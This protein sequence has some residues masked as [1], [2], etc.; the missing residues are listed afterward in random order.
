MVKVLL[1]GPVGTGSLRTLQT[2]VAKL[3]AS[4]NGP[5]D[6]LFCTDILAVDE[7]R[8][9]AAA[10]QAFSVP[11]F[12]LSSTSS[13]VSSVLDPFREGGASAAA[14]GATYLGACGVS[15]LSGL[16]VV[17][18]SLDALCDDSRALIKSL[19]EAPDALV[20][21]LMLSS[22]TPLGVLK[23]APD[24][25]ILPATAR[26]ALTGGSVVAAALARVAE[27]RY[28]VSGTANGAAYVRAPYINP[29]SSVVTRFLSLAPVPDNDAG[30][31]KGGTKHL[32]ALNLEPVNAAA[33]AAVVPGSTPSPY[34]GAAAAAAA[35]AAAVLLSA[36]APAGTGN[37]RSSGTSSVAPRST[38]GHIVGNFVPSSTGAQHP[39]ETAAAA[40]A[41]HSDGSFSVGGP[42]SKRPRMQDAPETAASSS[43]A[44]ASSSFPSQDAALHAATASSSTAPLLQCYSAPSSGLTADRIN[45]LESEARG[46]PGGQYFW[47]V[48]GGGPGGGTGRGGRGGRGG[49]YSSGR[50]GGGYGHANNGGG[51]GG[52]GPSGANMTQI[53]GRGGSG[54]ASDGA[55]PRWDN[56]R[57]SHQQQQRQQQPQRAPPECWF[58]LASPHVEKHLVVAIGN[59]CYLGEWRCRTA[60]AQR[61]CIFRILCSLF[62]SVYYSRNALGTR[63][64]SS[65]WRRHHSYCIMRLRCLPTLLLQRFLKAASP[66]ITSWWCP[67]STATHSQ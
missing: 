6:V 7:L 19:A 15:T 48:R 1:A 55:D 46:V 3:N 33:A 53:E 41:A 32:H 63:K 40:A 43:S 57:L 66:R 21:D 27:P 35:A 16:R 11:T 9:A 5:F 20:Y 13:A 29:A 4:A 59:E 24:A 67:L 42:S 31:N 14:S 18:S 60:C 38:V 44:A 8:E 26:A 34:S 25:G 64:H 50:G 54:G 37:T 58:C 52:G 61:M 10:G 56:N 12:F 62:D 45:A 39:N 30:A 65:S 28:H 22:A 2:K 23:G 47:N 17:F 49:G 36:E 51:G